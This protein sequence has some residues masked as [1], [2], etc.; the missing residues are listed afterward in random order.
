MHP[1]PPVLDRIDAP[2][3]GPVSRRGLS[4]AAAGPA[5][6]YRDGSGDAAAADGAAAPGVA[7]RPAGPLGPGAGGALGPGVPGSLAAA[8]WFSGA[9]GL[10]PETTSRNG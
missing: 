6:G 3:A 5:G 2:A 7:P 4:Q 9:H 1:V 10:L 8:D